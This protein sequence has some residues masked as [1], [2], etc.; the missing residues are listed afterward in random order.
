MI[1]GKGQYYQEI[2]LQW[3]LHSKF[4][5]KLIYSSIIPIETKLY[6]KYRIPY[7]KSP[8]TQQINKYFSCLNLKLKKSCL[9]QLLKDKKRHSECNTSII[10]KNPRSRFTKSSSDLQ[11]LLT[12]GLHVLMAPMRQKYGASAKFNIPGL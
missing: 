11:F 7:Q 10:L 5:I 4:I 2:K 8:N 6:T 9:E 12:K 3:Y 1:Q